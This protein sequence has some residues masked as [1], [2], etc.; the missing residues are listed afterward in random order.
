MPRDDLI[1]LGD[2]RRLHASVMLFLIR[3]LTSANLH[4]HRVPGSKP[5]KMLSNN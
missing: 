1:M 5:L 3:I 4:V 2:M